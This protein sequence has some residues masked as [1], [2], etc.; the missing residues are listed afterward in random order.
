M[1]ILENEGTFFSELAGSNSPKPKTPFRV[2]KSRSR[3]EKHGSGLPAFPDKH[4][5]CPEYEKGERPKNASLWGE[6]GGE[7]AR[8]RRRWT[9][10]QIHSAT[11]R[12]SDT[13]LWIWKCRPKSPPVRNRR[14]D[15]SKEKKSTEGSRCHKLIGKCSLFKSERKKAMGVRLG[16]RPK[17]RVK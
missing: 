5:R 2:C 6:A 8:A 9:N 15:G 14:G 16:N 7:K 3:G 11:G 12:K 10:A 1:A 13:S 17:P 4:D